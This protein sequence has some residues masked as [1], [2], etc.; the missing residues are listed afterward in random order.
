MLKPTKKSYFTFQIKN[1]K[2]ADQTSRMCRLVCTF[3]V[4]KQQSKG[5]SHTDPYDVEAKAFWL[6]PCC[7]HGMHGQ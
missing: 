7:A 1:N 5:F 4:C 3:V 6:L 2:R